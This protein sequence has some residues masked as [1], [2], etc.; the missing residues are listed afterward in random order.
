MS[1]IE[2]AAKDLFFKLRNRF[3]RINMGDEKGNTTSNPTDARF[4]N[5]DYEENEVKFGNITAS[6]SDGQSLKLYY[7]QDVTKYMD[8]DEK[9]Q[10]FQLLQEIRKFAKAHM[11]G[12]DIR[13][14]AKDALNHKDMEFV[15][16]QNQEKSQ[17]G[18]SRV[19]W[20][21]RGTVSEGH[22]GNVKIHVMHSERMDENPNNRLHRVDRIFLV[23][24]SGERFLLPFKS[25][26]AA[27]AMANHV[28]LGG[29]PYDNS[30]RLIC[31]A[32]TEMA[33]LRR[34]ASATRRQTFE[35]EDAMQV[36]HA[37]S[38]IKES[39]KRS[40]FRMA[41]NSRFDE[42]MEDLGKLLS[43]QD[44]VEDIKPYFTQNTYNENLDNWI[45]SAAKAFKRYKGNI[46]ENLKESAGTVAQKLKDPNFKLVLKIA[47]DEDR[48]I[49]SSKYTDGRA[50]LRRILGTVA[51]R[52]SMENS[53]LANWASQIG[54]DM[55][56]GNASDEDMQI[57]LQLAKR[58][59]E[60]MKKIQNSPEAATELRV[61]KFGQNQ[62]REGPRNP[63]NETAEF[64][65]FVNG[66]GEEDEVIEDESDQP[67][68][69]NPNSFT[70]NVAAGYKAAQDNMARKVIGGL[71]AAGR[72]A[73]NPGDALRASTEAPPSPM[74][75]SPDEPMSLGQKIGAGYKAA[76]DNMANKVLG[77][78][79]A[80]GDIANNPGDALNRAAGALVD[81]P[82]NNGPI[83]TY[84]DTVH[85]GIKAISPDAARRMDAMDKNGAMRRSGTAPSPYGALDRN[86]SLPEPAPEKDP[87]D[88]ERIEEIDNFK[89][90][91]GKTDR[92]ES[93]L[94]GRI[95][96]EDEED[97]FDKTIRSM[98]QQGKSLDDI[99]DYV[100]TTNPSK[101]VFQNSSP[102]GP[103]AYNPDDGFPARPQYAPPDIF[104]PDWMAKT[105]PNL[106]ESNEALDTMLWLSGLKK[107]SEVTEAEEAP[108]SWEEIQDNF[109][110]MTSG[111]SNT[112]VEPPA[113]SNA[114]KPTAAATDDVLAKK[115]ADIDRV[116]N[117]WK[118]GQPAEPLAPSNVPKLPASSMAVSVPGTTTASS[119]AVPVP[120]AGA[121]SSSS[122]AVPVPGARYD[123]FNTG[124]LPGSGK[125]TIPDP[126]SRVTGAL[127]YDPPPTRSAPSNALAPSVQAKPPATSRNAPPT[128][129]YEPEIKIPPK[130]D[131]KAPLPKEIGSFRASD[132]Q[133]I[134]PEGLGPYEPETKIPPKLDK[135]SPNPPGAK[136]RPSELLGDPKNTNAPP[137]GPLDRKVGDTVAPE[138][139]ATKPT[140][141]L[142]TAARALRN[143]G[144]GAG[145]GAGVGAILNPAFDAPDI[146][147]RAKSGD[148]VGAASDLGT[149]VAKGAALG[150]LGGA[151]GVA[152]I[153][154]PIVGAPMAALLGM[155]TPTGVGT[156]TPKAALAQAKLDTPEKIKDYED[157]YGRLGWDDG[158]LILPPGAR[159]PKQHQAMSAA[160]AA[161]GLDP[162]ST[163]LKRPPP[164]SP[165]NFDP[166]MLNPTVSQRQRNILYP[167]RIDDPPSVDEQRMFESV[168]LRRIITLSGIGN[169]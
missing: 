120:G 109:K 23:N 131:P 166:T 164:Q 33:N 133:R 40:L 46:M 110:R 18:E 143:V 104:D 138:P 126:A 61:E 16:K 73:R 144:R 57:A 71:G 127:S 37:A 88:D 153:V 90:S 106:R 125:F 29:N 24:E 114:T 55:E 147:D 163:K 70:D 123:R 107:K 2:Q 145:V 36:I 53:D 135:N 9:L 42:S 11:L 64:E 119:M 69:T 87:A 108:L 117:Q 115:I 80:A 93:N 6:L 79:R 1:G 47:D 159:T 84:I 113:P 72:I 27:K 165:P 95:P 54:Q 86:P 68:A 56:H 38:S 43:E 146:Y 111:L 156:L 35:S 167:R 32:V 128:V 50:L 105:P 30:G 100:K 31:T 169:K 149:S 15:A 48:L 89:E 102:E 92:P 155:T 132:A 74:Q 52:V 151:A 81:G 122:L 134:P 19:L 160:V 152:P 60:D 124:P 130:I 158:S 5:F 49:G 3:P 78:L 28:G 63:G 26:V 116:S 157:T 4:F 162:T 45:G 118:S 141:P 139:P 59:V 22:V 67:P 14:I 10:W 96:D 161:G 83:N 62:R 12:L 168:E 136:I 58:Y 142:S 82:L 112:E 94:L 44:D 137:L 17:L 41:N 39:I 7:S 97:E 34:F 77:G 20:A 13:D 85:S 25:I 91:L 76:Q 8:K 154:G 103:G 66:I 75:P 150:A 140:A 98:A 101:P 99:I 21:R 65:S 148:Y 121:S 129:P 51:D